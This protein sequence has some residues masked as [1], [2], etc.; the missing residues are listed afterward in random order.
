MF[1][2]VHLWFRSVIDMSSLKQKLAFSYGLL[3]V[4]IFAVS[5]WSIYHLLTLGRAIDVILVNNY[6]S[7]LAA[8]NMKEA[9]E[10]QD[11]A[12]L[13]FIASHEEKARQ[14]LEDNA[15][16]F[17][18]EYQIAANNI[19]EEGEAELVADVDARYQ[20]YK[21][22]LEGLLQGTE[23]RTSSEQSAYYFARLEPDFLALKNK[24]D[25]LLRLNQQAMVRASERATSVSKRAEISTAMMA[26]LAV[27][28]ALIFAWRFTRYVVDPIA[29]L[30]HKARRIGEGDLDQH[31]ETSSRDEIGVLASEFNRMSARLRDLRR[32]DYGRLLV[33]QKKS[34]VVIDSIYEPV[35]VTDARGRMIKMNNAAR[36]LFG[37]AEGN[38]GRGGDLSLSELS[39]GERILRAV[40][41]AVAMQRPVAAEDA[42]ALVPVTVDGAERSFRLRATPMRD[43][44]GHLIGAVTLLEDVTS[45][46]ELDKL[47]TQFI[48]VAST[49][50]REPLRSLQLALHAVIQGGCGELTEEQTAMLEDA[51]DNAEKLDELMR[52]LLDL[53][54]IESGALRLA[55]E[56][57]RPIEL[58]RDALERIRFA[59]EAKHITLENNVWPDLQWVI[60]DRKAVGRIFD[61]VLSNALRH[62]PRDG[63]ITIEASERVG[64]V[65][66]SVRD[67]GEGIPAEAL[68]G[69]FRRFVQVGDKPEGTALGLA[70]V[71]RLVEAQGGQVSVESR[72]TEGAT[73]TFSL[74]VGGPSS[75][76]RA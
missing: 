27:T 8:E 29:A 58:A 10:R 68:P 12:A 49:K 63:R 53:A 42:A 54:E 59:A 46:A 4:V 21:H 65:L 23:I 22:R 28:V 72:L 55:T 13:F 11:S 15:S 3:I 57:L 24:L 76:K 50:L 45:L 71:K 31:I 39:G 20:G 62:T 9:L 48:S 75:V 38:G 44:D 37:G 61:N 1:I 56:R 69:L 6:R 30:T 73:F 43:S 18:L 40:R 67:T 7:I 16:K 70:L 25:E 41:D 2:F 14:Q 35:I 60:A 5:A 34:D 36:H 26:T 64:R 19:T 51:R 52:D 47:K 66:F 17:S 33:E 32:S 74:P